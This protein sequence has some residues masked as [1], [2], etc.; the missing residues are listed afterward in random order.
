M[1]EIAYDALSKTDISWWVIFVYGF[2][3]SFEYHL[4]CK[5][6]KNK[7]HLKNVYYYFTLVKQEIYDDILNLWLK[8]TN[9]K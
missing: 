9:K 2:C 8:M 1:L 3:L 5:I 7:T 4:M 6:Y